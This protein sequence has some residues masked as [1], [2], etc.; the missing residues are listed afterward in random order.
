MPSVRK[1]GPALG[2]RE[3]FRFLD[4]PEFLEQYSWQTQE[5][6]WMDFYVEGVHCAACVWLT[7]KIADIVDDVGFIR[8]NLGN[9]VATVR[10]HDQGS[11]SAVALEL[12][13]MGYRPHPIKQDE[14]RGLQKRENRLL[15]MRLGVAGACAGNIMLLAV[16]LYGGANGGIADRFRWISL[17]L[18]VP[19]I[20][21]SAVPFYKSA[22]ISLRSKELSIDIPVVFGILLGSIV[23][24]IN[25]IQGD[26]RIYFDS[27]SAL[28]F[29]LLSTRYLLKRTQQSALDFSRFL[30]FLTPMWVKKWNPSGQIYEEVR[31]DQLSAGDRVQV[32]PN[33]CVPVDGRVVK[34]FSSLDCALLSGESQ[35]ERVAVGDRVFAGTLNLDAPL[36]IEVTQSGVNTRMGRILVSMEKL[37]TKK[38]AATVFAD[39]VSRYFVSAVVILSGA[40]IIFSFYN[41]WG[42]YL[43]RALAIAIVTCPCTFALITPLAFSLTLGKLARGGV[44]VKGPDILEKLAGVKA[45]FFDKTGT[46]TFGALQV[47]HWEVPDELSAA[48]LAI[49]SCSVHPIAKA[50]TQYLR[51]QV[52]GVI[53]QVEEL[54]EKMGNGICG[55]VGGSWYELTRARDATSLSTEISI[56]KDGLLVGRAVLSDQVRPESQKV[57]Q[58]LKSLNLNLRIL[59][60]DHRGSVKQVADQVGIEFGSCIFEASP[61]KK[62]EVIKSYENTLMVGDGANDAIALAQ[63]DVGIAVHSSME[64]SLQAAGVFLKTPGIRSVYHLVVI[65]RETLSVVQRNFWFSVVYNVIA[66]GFAL[67]GKID[68]LFAAVLMPM[69]ALTVLLSSIT[70]TSRM[71]TAFKEINA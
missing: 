3:E 33:E 5:G 48:I 63:A 18:Y 37:L 51:N 34:G 66:G 46:L 49:E 28:V 40:L 41:S 44:L 6:R 65:A 61:E 36:E 39:R 24:V 7:E 70:G 22:W 53:P 8:L 58:L 32:F 21:F 19:V 35:S 71:R 57:V 12:Q 50:M 20:F 42:D 29:L 54:K 30:H 23:S 69:S 17:G 27:L 52:T 62:N 43:N 68:P 14:Q 47:T 26:D 10:I 13:K 56:L 38:A 2:A 16:S 67:A 11:F 1:S 9:S 25:L 15:L 31:M 60:G 45:V 64:L 59:S 55:R 4:D